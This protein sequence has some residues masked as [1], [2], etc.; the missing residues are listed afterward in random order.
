MTKAPLLSISSPET[1]T[2]E[3]WLSCV[4]SDDHHPELTIWSAVR[5]EDTNNPTVGNSHSNTRNTTD[6]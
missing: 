1:R 3:R 5:K 4:L 6:K 2:G